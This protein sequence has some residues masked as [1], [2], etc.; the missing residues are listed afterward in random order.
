[1]SDNHPWSDVIHLFKLSRFGLREF[2]KEIHA[3]RMGSD[4]S[5]F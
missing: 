1:M 2:G 3:K 5:F 4:G